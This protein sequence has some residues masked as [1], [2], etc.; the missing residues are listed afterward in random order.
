MALGAA[1][2]A[3]SVS[4]RAGR[5]RTG[6]T[7]GPGGHR[8]VAPDRADLGRRLARL[9][10]RPTRHTRRPFLARA[11]RALPTRRSLVPP[12]RKPLSETSLNCEDPGRSR[13]LA[14]ISHR[15][16]PSAPAR[17]GGERGARPSTRQTTLAGPDP[18]CPAWLPRLLEPPSRFL[19]AQS[20]EGRLHDDVRNCGHPACCVTGIAGQSPGKSEGSRPSPRTKCSTWLAAPSDP[21]R[22]TANCRRSTTVASASRFSV[23][24][25]MAT[26]YSRRA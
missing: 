22:L 8:G 7:A 4:P 12:R 17:A 3:D 26:P 24:G 1:R 23:S 10:L 13:S 20:P 2:P 15:F 14:A 25:S 18:S 19:T 6:S 9:R 16:A 21:S 5:R 11:S